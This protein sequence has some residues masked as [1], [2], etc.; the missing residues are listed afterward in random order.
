MAPDDEN[1]FEEQRTPDRS[2]PAP[3]ELRDS[4][5]QRMLSDSQRQRHA[6]R[7]SHDV[8]VVAMLTRPVPPEEQRH[9][10]ELRRSP[11][12]AYEVAWHLAK[13]MRRLREDEATG[14]RERNAQ[15]ETILELPAR[16]ETLEAQN[17]FVRRIAYALAG[18]LLAGVVWVA[19]L[20]SSSS[21]RVGTQTEKIHTLERDR[22]AL[23]RDVHDLQQELGRFRRELGRN[24]P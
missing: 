21:E 6:D 10:E 14:R 8:P 13:E 24:A 22:E 5:R 2:A 15:A 17:A 19:N 1:E 16:I 7:W 3:L 11:V 20:I 9:I 12:D 18:G 4:D 23:E